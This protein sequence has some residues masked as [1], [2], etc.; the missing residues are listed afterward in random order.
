MG[1]RSH[2]PPVNQR[3]SSR[4][5][6][7]V[8]QPP[9][10]VA[11]ADPES[12]YQPQQSS[13]SYHAPFSP[14]MAQNNP[15]VPYPPSPHYPTLQSYPPNFQRI[16]YPTTPPIP[17]HQYYYSYGQ[18]PLGVPTQ[19]A[20]R[21]HELNRSHSDASQSYSDLSQQP[22]HGTPGPN[23]PSMASVPYAR[24]TYA[25]PIPYPYSMAPP[26]IPTLP[27]VYASTNTFSPPVAQMDTS[28]EYWY[29]S[30]NTPPALAESDPSTSH[31]AQSMS[32]SQSITPV[33]LPDPSRA[34]T[35]S[36]SQ[37]WA[38]QP[39][40]PAPSGASVARSGQETITKDWATRRRP[41]QP[42]PPANRSEWVMWVGNIPSDCDRDELQ[43][44]FDSVVWPSP[45]D[46]P[47]DGGPF[48]NEAETPRSGVMSVFLISQ[49]NCAFVNYDSEARL[50]NAVAKCN[51]VAI[52]PDDPR[53]IKLVC[54]VRKKDEDLRAGVGAQRGVR[55]HTAWVQQQKQKNKGNQFVF[56]Q[57]PAMFPLTVPNY[58][59]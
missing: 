18:P 28:P 47:E 55:M 9:E 52:R 4:E 5:Q 14:P 13:A 33:R 7:N 37:S 27:P 58:A 2:R 15:N 45:S 16:P 19:Y 57:A 56:F 12:S 38:V 25:A 50:L 54:R 51:G 34:S 3:Q 44:F 8:S 59:F 41:H 6:S 20:Y 21:P 31:P 30:T 49:S 42:H 36:R 29:T 43:R 22:R 17:L 39:D 40:H 10:A 11:P 46:F 26:S 32:S 48:P 24:M 23:A 53:C 1:D 35:S